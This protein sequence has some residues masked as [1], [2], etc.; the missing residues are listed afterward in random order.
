MTRATQKEM[1]RRIL[2]G[3]MHELE[4][5]PALIDEGERP[6]FVVVLPELGRVGVE[7]TFYTAPGDRRRVEAAWDAFIEKVRARLPSY[8]W[9]KGVSV[10]LSFDP[11]SLPKP[12]SW[13]GFIEEIATF[14]E[15]MIPHLEERKT[16]EIDIPQTGFQLM[17]QHLKFLNARRPDFFLGFYVGWN[18]NGNVGFID[19]TDAELCAIVAGKA[20][21]ASKIDGRRRVD[22]QWL[23]VHDG[24]SISQIHEP[25]G[26]EQLQSFAG[27]VKALA[28]G[29][30]ARVYP[31][32]SSTYC[33]TAETGWRAVAGTASGIRAE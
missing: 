3:L 16:R 23:I 11:L 28:H 29:P 30:F 31:L 12:Q 19:V 33:W 26:T 27:L 25:L 18:W 21:K 6:D 5:A 17:R 24:W 8:P 4:L 2:N 14:L 7:L 32:G 20:E 13:P 22:E 1:E 10:N 15:P 9:M